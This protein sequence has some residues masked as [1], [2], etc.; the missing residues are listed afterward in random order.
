MLFVTTYCCLLANVAVHCLLPAAACCCLL[1]PANA[2]YPVQ[3]GG[4]GAQRLVLQD[5]AHEEEDQD[6][7]G[8]LPQRESEAIAREE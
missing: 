1:L 6:I 8:N 7:R 2:M 3:G 5:A 4:R